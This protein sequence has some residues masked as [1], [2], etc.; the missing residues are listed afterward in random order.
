MSDSAATQTPVEEIESA[1]RNALGA[2][3][4]IERLLGQG[5][6]SVVFLA[7]E[8]NLGRPVALK[9]FPQSLA[10]EKSA[11]DRFRHEARIA[12]SLEHPHIAPIH[13]FGVAPGFLW[14]TMKFIKGRSLAETLKEV[15]RLDMFSVLSLT[16]Q[17][18]S[19]LD[20]AHQHGI[21]HRDMKPAN[22]MLDDNNWAYVCDFGVA[23]TQNTKLTQTGGTIGT[24]AY[25][26]PEQLYGR[27]LDG[28]SDQYSLAVVVFELL[29]GRHP[30]PGESVADIVQMHC[31]TP[32][33]PLS[34][35]RDDLPERLVQGVQ[36]AM[37]KKPDDRF[38]SVVAFLTAIG[39]R[40]PPQAPQPRLSLPASEAV[41]ERLELA[42]APPGPR[43][44]WPLLSAGVVLGALAIWGVSFTPVGHVMGIR[45]EATIPTAPTAPGH[46][47]IRSEPWGHVYIDGDSIGITV[48]NRAVAAGSHLL[49]IQRA[50]YL[51]LEQSFDLAP[52]QELRLTDLRL[53][54]AP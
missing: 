4:R 48:I 26:S 54:P 34:D 23:K 5:G 11:Q 8:L 3:Y 42:P 22:V 36:R 13:R 50:G 40:R 21:V 43:R 7:E 32:P 17:A 27:E 12:A 46:V 35:F 29:A 14:Y 28:R 15:G 38:E 41:T 52:G 47:W 2:E 37:S 45:R 20:Y 10:I 19:A 1:V 44:R 30:F 33:P 53:K 18:A 24:P 39:G 16:E 9:V 31:T 25:M 49:R 6:M 51:P